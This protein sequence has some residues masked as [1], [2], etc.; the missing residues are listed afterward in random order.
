M[1]DLIVRIK[2]VGLSDI[3][4]W[5]ALSN[6][7]D[8]Y[9][10]EIVSDITEW[11]EG[12]ETSTSFN[13]YMKAKIHQNEAFMATGANGTCCGIVAISKTNNRITY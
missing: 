3:F 2:S 4:V 11:Y 1:E 12:N 7:Y 13:D 6:E 5:T 8:I 10:K 9:V